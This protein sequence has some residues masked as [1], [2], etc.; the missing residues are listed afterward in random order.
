[1]TP[2]QLWTYANSLEKIAKNMKGLALLA[3]KKHKSLD[4][5]SLDIGEL[6]LFDTYTLHDNLKTLSED[7]CRNL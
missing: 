2:N 3:R 5:L 7:I 4:D 6:F 1:M